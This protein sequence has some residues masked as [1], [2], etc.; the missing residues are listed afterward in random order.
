M[1]QFAAVLNEKK[2]K[3]IE[4]KQ[5]A[6]QAQESIQKASSEVSCISNAVIANFPCKYRTFS[7]VMH[8]FPS[9]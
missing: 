8:G 7:A 5:K 4:W 6:E 9:Q 2:A 1:L 3:A